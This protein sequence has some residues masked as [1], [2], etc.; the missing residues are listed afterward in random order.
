MK[1]K[2][3]N[4]WLL[5]YVQDNSNEKEEHKLVVCARTRERAIELFYKEQ[6]SSWYKTTN[7]IVKS[8]EPYEIDVK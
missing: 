2:I 5:T 6:V 1:K 3:K 8:I 4:L 7:K